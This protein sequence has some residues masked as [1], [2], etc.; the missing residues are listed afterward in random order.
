MML[1]K[2]EH[3][4]MILNCKKTMTRRIWKKP[5]AL[6][7]SIHQA[8]T[9]L[10]GKPFAYLK[11]LNVQKQRLQSIN[12]EDIIKE[13]YKTFE[14]FYDKWVEINGNWNIYQEVYVIEFF[15]IKEDTDK[16]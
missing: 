11:I 7:G 14:S 8:R 13:G 15:V 1:F 16:N 10:F 12:H 3:V 9:E 4:P 6:I 2:P 5:R